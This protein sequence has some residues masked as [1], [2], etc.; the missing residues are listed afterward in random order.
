MTGPCSQNTVQYK[1]IY[2]YKTKEQ[3]QE[4]VFLT[5]PHYRIHMAS[6]VTYIL[7]IQDPRSSDPNC[8]NPA[9]GAPP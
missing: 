1:Y 3:D 8:A 2:I 7:N 9:L 4:M 6:H 5:V